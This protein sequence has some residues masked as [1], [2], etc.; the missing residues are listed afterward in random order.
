M[1]CNQA[2]PLALRHHQQLEVHMPKHDF[3]N[4]LQQSF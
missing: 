2:V 1:S 3:N 4:E